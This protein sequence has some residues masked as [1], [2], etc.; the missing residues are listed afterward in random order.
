MILTP[1]ANLIKLYCHNY[2]SIGLTSVKII[3]KNTTSGINYAEKSFT[4]SGPGACTITLFTAVNFKYD[5]KL[6][7]LANLVTFTLV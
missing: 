2:I 5:N 6:E 4:I 1:S 3:W 7:C